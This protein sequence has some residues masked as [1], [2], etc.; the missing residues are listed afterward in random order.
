G[1]RSA[2]ID[3]NG[4]ASLRPSV[5]D[6]LKDFFD[7]GAEPAVGVAAAKTERHL[8]ANHLAHHVG[9]AARNV[10]RMGNDHD[11]DV[12]AHPLPST[13]SQTAS[14]ISWLERAPGSMCPIERSP[15]N[16][17]RPLIAFIGI[18]APAAVR[19][20]SRMLP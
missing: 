3:Q 15:R 7:A 6:R 1:F 2:E 16:D 14:I 9:R 18:V 8:L 12:V 17:A 4:D 5:I 13:M 20:F 11:S 10:G 19:A